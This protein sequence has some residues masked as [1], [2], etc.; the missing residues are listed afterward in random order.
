MNFVN[1]VFEQIIDALNTESKFVYKFK[2]GDS[3][4]IFHTNI[5]SSSDVPKQLFKCLRMVYSARSETDDELFHWTSGEYFY[6]WDYI[7]AAADF[8][9][10]VNSGNPA[11]DNP[12]NSI[13]SDEMVYLRKGYTL[14]LPKIN[15]E[16]VLNKTDLTKNEVF[17]AIKTHGEFT[18]ITIEKTVYKISRCNITSKDVSDID[19][20]DVIRFSSEDT[21]NRVSSYLLFHTKDINSAVEYFV[22]KVTNTDIT[23]SCTKGMSKYELRDELLLRQK[24]E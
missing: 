4:K 19:N 20:V 5:E 22:C 2:N 7:T 21:L 24:G 9:K 11:Y 3:L 16:T 13:D 18:H 6:P 12:Y 23:E 15:Y 8:M 17:K 10:R 14:C 1:I